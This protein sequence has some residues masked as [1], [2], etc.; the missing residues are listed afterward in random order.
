MHP[1]HLGFWT[2]S[3]HY[4][5]AL[6]QLLIN[7]PSPAQLIHTLVSL[8]CHNTSANVHYPRGVGRHNVNNF[9]DVSLTALNTSSDPTAIVC[10]DHVPL[11]QLYC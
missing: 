2:L 1:N 5:A 10:S 7:D 6:R 8:S 3:H 4:K 11:N 9:I